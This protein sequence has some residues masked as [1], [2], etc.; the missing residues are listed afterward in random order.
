MGWNHQLA[1]ND[2]Y[3]YG[4]RDILVEMRGCA[5]FFCSFCILWIFLEFEAGMWGKDIQK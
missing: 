1:N 4:I 5:V 3:I 2:F